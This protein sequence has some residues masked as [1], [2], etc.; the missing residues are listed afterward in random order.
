MVCIEFRHFIKPGNRPNRLNEFITTYCLNDLENIHSCKS[1]VAFLIFGDATFTRNSFAC[2]QP[3]FFLSL[4]FHKDFLPHMRILDIC[5][6][7]SKQVG[8]DKSKQVVSDKSKQVVCYNVTVL[9][10][11]SVYGAYNKL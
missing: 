8:S 3:F 7:K 4:I 10:F 1:I 5:T 6:N 2:L 9:Y 11:N